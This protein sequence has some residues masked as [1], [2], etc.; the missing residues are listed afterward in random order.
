MTLPALDSKQR[1]AATAPGGIVQIIARAGSGK[2]T[3]LVERIRQL[4]TRGA[5]PERILALTFNDA[6]AAELR[7][8]LRRAGITSVQART[9]HSIGH[10]IIRAHG[11]VEGR[12]LH[13]EGW[14][15]AQWNR[16][17]RIAADE[18]GVAPPDASELADEIAMIRLTRLV[19]TK[20]YERTDPGVLARVYALVEREKDLRRLYDFDDMIA[21]AVRLL[22]RDEQAAPAG[23]PP[24]T[25]CW[26]TSTRT[27]SPRRS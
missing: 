7:E 27:S 4:L 15:L 12:T 3:V 13:S 1:E 20:E 2:T 26:S 23:R 6:A 14:S 9:F 17:A 25:T 16:F 19:G 8:R 24:S 18:L 11:L 10:R 21:H 22:R 5:A